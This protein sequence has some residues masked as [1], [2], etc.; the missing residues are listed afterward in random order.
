MPQN[1]AKHRKERPTQQAAKSRKKDTQRTFWNDELH[2]STSAPSAVMKSSLHCDC[3]LDKPHFEM[4]RG[5]WGGMFR[6][7]EAEDG[8]GEISAR[9]C[10]PTGKPRGGSVTNGPTHPIRSR[11]D[12]FSPGTALP[13]LEKRLPMTD[14]LGGAVKNGRGG[15]LFIK[16]KR[17]K[18]M[19]N[20]PE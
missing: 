17:E 15:M 9:P 8:G 4:S 2:L 13:D 3:N 12:S 7:P 16:S 11:I 14:T 19:T 20:N 5:G 1:S 10:S 18:R 6:I